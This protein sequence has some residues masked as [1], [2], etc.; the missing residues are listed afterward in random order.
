[1][2]VASRFFACLGLATMVG[3]ALSAADFSDPTWP[4]IQRKVETLSVG[5]MFPYILPE[6]PEGSEDI[7]D[8]A[9]ELSAPLALRRFEIEEV[10]PWIDEYAAEHPSNAALGA[11]YKATFDRIDSQRRK[12]IAGIARYAENQSALSDRINAARAEMEE[13]MATE[14]PDFDRVD[15]LEEQLDWEERIYQDRQ[16]ALTY[17]CESPVLLEKRAYELGQIVRERWQEG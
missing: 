2:P 11:L 9:E 7:R 5:Q 4:C 12:I 8:R 6:L 16:R 17:V 13:I 14:D 10:E 1:M 3:P 15:T